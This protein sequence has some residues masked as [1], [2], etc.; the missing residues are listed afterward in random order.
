MA[1]LENLDIL[2][3]WSS[4]QTFGIGGGGGGGGTEMQICEEISLCLWSS[5]YCYQ[6]SSEFLFFIEMS[7][8]ST[9]SNQALDCKIKQIIPTNLILLPIQLLIPLYFLVFMLF[10]WLSESLIPWM[11]SCGQI[12]YRKLS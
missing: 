10:A 8:K 11:A 12:N 2:I 9:R 7:G 6:M 1:S 3:T 4:K 5:D